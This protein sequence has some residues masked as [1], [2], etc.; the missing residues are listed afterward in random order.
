[1]QIKELSVLTPSLERQLL[2]IWENAVRATHFFLSAAEIENIKE[3][4]PQALH[5]AAYLIVAED[6]D[7]QSVAFMGIDGQRLEML[8]VTPE[9]RGKG[10]GRQLLEYGIEKYTVSELTVNA[11]NPLAKAFYMHMGFQVYKRTDFDEQ[12]N[13][14]PLLYM[15]RM[16]ADLNFTE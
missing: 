2:N 10:I 13:P 9:K 11:Q 5:S 16:K 6:A 7:G 1:M 14:Y 12:G 3:Y 8:F 15:R 4:V